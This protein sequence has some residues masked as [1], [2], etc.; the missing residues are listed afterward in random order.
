MIALMQTLLPL[1]GGAGDEQMRHLREIGDDRLAV[2]I[3][4]ERER[5]LR[6]CVLCNRRSPA[7]RAASPFT[8]RLLAISMPTVSLPGIGAR[9]LIRS[10]R[11]A[12][13]NRAQG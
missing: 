3:L 7:T 2:N 12:R 6:L 13:A 5:E 1:P 9:I 10:A 11:V 4:A 8:L